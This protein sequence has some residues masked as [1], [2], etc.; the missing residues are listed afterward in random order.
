MSSP[1]N[2]S[3]AWGW[4]NSSS[5]LCTLAWLRNGT[6]YLRTEYLALRTIT[7]P[8]RCLLPADYLPPLQAEPHNMAR[9]DE[10]AKQKTLVF[11]GTNNH[12]GT[13]T[14]LLERRC[15]GNGVLHHACCRPA[16]QQC[17]RR[18]NRHQGE[19]CG[20]SV[21]SGCTLPPPAPSSPDLAPPQSDPNTHRSAHTH[22]PQAL[23]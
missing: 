5:A 22:M 1:K 20:K 9:Q 10:T 15:G 4:S 2:N 18:H 13:F 8:D 17:Q 21:C 6:Q 19:G 14:N 12:S 3:N 11:Q 16:C 23:N 7:M